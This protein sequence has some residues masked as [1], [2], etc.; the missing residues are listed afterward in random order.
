MRLYFLRHGET[1]WNVKRLVQGSTDIPLNEYGRY[2]ARETAK[3]FKDVPIDVVYTSPLIR[4]KETAQLV[5]ENQNPLY[6]DEPRIREMG[7]GEY[8]GM[9]ISGP[10]KSPKSP[11]FNKFFDDT[12]NF[13]PVEGGETMK[14]LMDRTGDFLQ[15]LYENEELEEKNVLISTH[16]VT[17]TALLNHIKNNLSVECFWCEEVP[18]NCGVT[19][20]EVKDGVPSILEESLVYYNEP[21]RK[22]RIEE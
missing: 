4:A 2:L 10:E 16:G 14:E 18:P 15:E 8:E 1:D 21:V 5:L 9:C 6:I 11:E 13:V 7:F 22:W 3:G 19:I 20:V 17:M 12:V